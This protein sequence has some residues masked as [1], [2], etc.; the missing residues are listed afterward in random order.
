MHHVYYC[1]P[2]KAGWLAIRRS[3]SPRQLDYR[4]AWLLQMAAHGQRSGQARGKSLN[5]LAHVAI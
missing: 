3:R 5:L 2:K 1:Q 4:N